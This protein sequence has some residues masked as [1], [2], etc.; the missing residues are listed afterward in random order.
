[1]GGRLQEGKG[2]Y[3]WVWL[4]D[5]LGSD[6]TWLHVIHIPYAFVTSDMVFNMEASVSLS[7]TWAVVGI[8]CAH[9]CESPL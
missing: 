4:G 9:A 6:M 2:E 8:P 3:G 5:Q 7:A 1:M